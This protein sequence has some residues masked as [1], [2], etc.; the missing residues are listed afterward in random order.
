MAKKKKPGKH[1]SPAQPAPKLPLQLVL[2]HRAVD[3]LTPDFVRWFADI[4]DPSD[5]LQC[6]HLV[7]G[8]LSAS[9]AVKGT[10][11]ATRVVPENLEDI[12]EAFAGLLDAEDAASA[13]AEIYDYLHLYVDFLMESG[14]WSGTEEDYFLV[15]SML[16][17]ESA[18]LGGHPGIDIPELGEEEKDRL[19]AE[20]ALVQHAS[21]LLSW[22]G[23]G[24]D[25]TST[26]MLRLKDIEEAAAAVG[27]KAVGKKNAK[28][29]YEPW[30]AE[31]PQPRSV[32]E[33]GTMQ[34]VPLLKD[35]WLA[36]ADSAMVSIGL[37]RAVPANAVAW[38][39]IEAPA[40]NDAR[41]GFVTEF[42]VR[43]LEEEAS[44]WSFDAPELNYLLA[45]VVLRGTTLEPLPV[46]ELREMSAEDPGGN[47]FLTI[48]AKRALSQAE[49]FVELGLFERGSH[50]AVPPVLRQS[51]AQA[52]AI[53]LQG[54]EAF[55]PDDLEQTPEDNV[56]PFPPPARI[57]ELPGHPDGN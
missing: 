19:F 51:A 10:G 23:R 36:L 13:S 14:H 30:E 29:P 47:I 40:R 5:A 6:L 33:V 27:V 42:L 57:V 26:G 31:E 4:G 56:I 53:V 11:S 20:I 22:I 34:D 21:R 52:A 16:S 50:Y 39:H 17:E 24:R 8:F 2:E 32:L 38:N 37:T 35:I 55:G 7:K 41:E 18:G 48:A 15:H 9:H 46:S 43:V 1:P 28:R 45:M 44:F 25:V 49:A 3:S 54:S 12:I